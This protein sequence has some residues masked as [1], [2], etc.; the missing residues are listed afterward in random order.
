M[1]LRR[2]LALVAAAAV[3][4]AAV[5]VAIVSYVAVAHE[6]RG[7]VDDALR[8]Q[9]AL[10]TER[11]FFPRPGEPV[12]GPPPQEGESATYVQVVEPDG[13]VTALRGP[14][15]PA[16]AVAHAIAQ[17]GRG[18]VLRDV[19]AGGAHLRVLTFG[20]PG[21]GALELG[22]SLEQVD[23]VVA[24]LRLVLLL[25][26]GGGIALAAALGAAAS[27]SLIAPLAKVTEA[28]R[29]IG[30]TED[31]ARRIEV[32]TDDEV[33]E[34][35]RRFNGM[36]D[37]L[38]ASRAALD[39]SMRAQRQLV[40][41]ASHE[42]RTPIT[43]LRTNLEVLMDD[44]PLS[45]DERRRLLRDLT[46][47]VEELGLLVGDLIELARGDEPAASVHDDVRLDALVSEALDRARL[48]APDAL[49]HAELEP[50]VVNGA[51]DRLAR[52]VAN[53]LDN[54]AKH[55]RPGTP[56][57]VVVDAAGMTVRDHGD[58]IPPDDLPSI[59]DR[60]YRGAAA[61]GS[62]GSGLGLA[63]VRQVA[64]SHGGRATA[65]NAP[66]GGAVF[67]LELPTSPVAGATPAA[68]RAPARG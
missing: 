7:E 65:A 11:P 44:R 31:L 23:N 59:F 22:R 39:D 48:H 2:R 9:A 51:P 15:L 12:P 21:G 29:H 24:R 4:V 20:L 45:A 54:A 66:D 8:R 68:R 43:S 27:R 18:D 63:I 53:L 6:L 10:I 13:N 52:A 50:V 61:R 19:R 49:F 40:A 3:G 28:A 57:E 14:G 16:D 60:F 42:L 5:F 26:A 46:A 34:L 17:E 67:R 62:A 47:Q 56:V 33:G 35:A 25:V 37:T 32:R 55:T 58:G 36:L 64:E 1:S 41:D 30:E 38:A